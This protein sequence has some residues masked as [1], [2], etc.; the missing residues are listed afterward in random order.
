M[1][2]KKKRLMLA[3]SHDLFNVLKAWGKASG[4]PSS[5]MV[6]S[7]LEENKPIF[8]AMTAAIEAQKRGKE[9]EAMKAMAVLTG[10]ALSHLGE[11]MKG[12][13]ST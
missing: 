13:K 11:A 7:F 6:A 4:L 1:P 9:A 2:T 5:T 10:A 3:L 12:K 8:Q